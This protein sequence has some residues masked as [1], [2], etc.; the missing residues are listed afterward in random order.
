[1]TSDASE[2][3][4]RMTGVFPPIQPIELTVILCVCVCVRSALR[5]R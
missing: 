4:A 2:I 3:A 5:L 1:M